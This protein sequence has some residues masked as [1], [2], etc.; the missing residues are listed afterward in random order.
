[1]RRVVRLAESENAKRGLRARYSLTTNGSL[2]TPGI[3][4]FLSRHRFTVTVSY[5][6]PAQDAQRRR[7]SSAVLLSLLERIGR[8]AR[9]RLRVNSVFTPRS[10][11][12]LAET[13]RL[14]LNLG[15][16]DFSFSLSVLRP[17]R[18][19]ALRRLKLELGKCRR[20]VLAHF[21]RTGRLPLENFRERRAGGIFRCAGGRD[22]L[23]LAPDG[24]VW[25]CYMFA[26][27]D[28]RSGRRARAARVPL[29]GSA[30]LDELRRNPEE[31]LA[32][33][34]A[35]HDRLSMDAFRTAER[36]CF[37]CPEVGRCAVCPAGAA[38]A[39]GA[40]LGRI[41]VR[42]CRIQR[43]LLAARSRFE[44]CAHSTED[45]RTGRRRRRIK[46]ESRAIP[47]QTF[48][49]AMPARRAAAA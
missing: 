38:A 35:W 26:G 33:L 24:R 4:R 36:E 34:R 16:P 30:T 42:V 20:L 11:S 5:D 13:M 2:M 1:M 23:A 29:A 14:L 31:V 8:D 21:R 46:T 10:V 7:G 39:G 45:R 17:W 43:L 47:F 9:L 32:R 6:G 37:L 40:P 19:P 48:R 28:G 15:V 49:T 22:R 44:I 41:P 25:G 27:L 3:L 12:R 18:E